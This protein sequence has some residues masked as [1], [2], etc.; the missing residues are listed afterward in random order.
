M[1]P[2][3]KLSLPRAGIPA[4]IPIALKYAPSA[5]MGFS[6]Y[7][8]YLDQR[9]LWIKTLVNQLWQQ[10]PIGALLQITIKEAQLELGVTASLATLPNRNQINGLLWAL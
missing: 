9:C 2:I 4:H 6:I 3:T 7:D 8:P 1:A 5:T 10:I